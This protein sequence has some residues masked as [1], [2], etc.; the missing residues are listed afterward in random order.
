[1][2][3]EHRG[4]TPANAPVQ[5]APPMRIALFTTIISR[6][7]FAAAFAGMSWALRANGIRDVDIVYYKGD[8]AEPRAG[9]PD[10]VRFVKLAGGRGLRAMGPLR[11]YLDR[12]RPDFLISAP[13]FVNLLAIVSSLGSRWRRRGGRLIITHHHP[14]ELAHQ[15]CKK[16]NKWLAKG[17][18]RFASGS[19]GVSPGAVSDA[20]HEVGLDPAHVPCIPN[21]LS[22]A[23]VDP[24]APTHPWL[25]HKEHPVFISVSRLVKLKNIDLLLECFTDVAK[26]S[27]ARLL[28]CGDGPERAHLQRLIEALALGDRVMLCGYVPNSRL[29][30]MKADAF[31]LASNEEGFGQVLTEAMSVGCPVI[32]TR[33][34]GGGAEYVLDGGRYGVLVPCGDRSR[35]VDAM[36]S[37]L[38]AE[39]RRSYAARSL[40]R[41][42]DFLPARVGSDLI[43]FLQR[44]RSA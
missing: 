39:T 2:T 43:A 6:G 41:V 25:D 26:Q 19:F 44:C 10:N 30:M 20:C 40:E 29:F 32:S 8:L 37:M 31:V 14:I 18:Y 16:D 34:L 21:I 15:N 36:L 23:D 7:A 11:R 38:D 24:H 22:P 33:S 27:D 28:I 3:A 35:L 42:Q 1:V 13:V 12:T 17:L 9:F 5:T 4:I